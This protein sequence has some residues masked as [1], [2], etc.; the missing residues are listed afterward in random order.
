MHTIDKPSNKLL[1][2]GD[3]NLD[4]LKYEIHLPTSKY[5]DIMTN[6]CT[7]PRITRPTRIKNQSATLIDHIFTWDNPTTLISGIIDTELKGSSGFTD[8]KPTF[9]ILQAILPKDKPNK[10]I[11]ISYFTQECTQ[12]IKRKWEENGKENEKE[13]SNDNENDNDN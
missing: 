7:L 11:K 3:M 2:A 1:I 6:H 9:T 10:L 12:K 4:L 5:I 13:N 8:H